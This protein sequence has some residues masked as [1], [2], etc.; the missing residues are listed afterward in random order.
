[1]YAGHPSQE[2]PRLLDPDGDPRFPFFKDIPDIVGESGASEPRTVAGAEL[3]RDEISELVE[4]TKSA[5]DDGKL[6]WS[7]AISL[8]QLATKKPNSKYAPEPNTQYKCVYC[9]ET[10]RLRDVDAVVDSYQNVI[11]YRCFERLPIQSGVGGREE[12]PW[13]EIG[14]LSLEIRN[15]A[16]RAWLD[17]KNAEYCRYSAAELKLLL[18]FSKKP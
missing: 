10:V 4:S 2:G 13:R 15:L 11:H 3:G 12:S 8:I 14:A 18:E 17:K 1:M 9:N 7:E 6:G 16:H 5:Y